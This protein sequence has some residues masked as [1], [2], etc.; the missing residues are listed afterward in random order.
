[1]SGVYSQVQRRF[2][3][4]FI[5][6]IITGSRSERRGWTVD[7]PNECWALLLGLY[8]VHFTRLCLQPESRGVN[9][10]C[11][12]GWRDVVINVSSVFFVVS[13][14]FFGWFYKSASPEGVLWGGGQRSDAEMWSVQFVRGR[15][16]ARAEV[17]RSIFSGPPRAAPQLSGTSS[18]DWIALTQ[19]SAPQSIPS[20]I[21]QLHSSTLL[22]S[23]LSGLHLTCDSKRLNIKHINVTTTEMCR[24]A[25]HIKARIVKSDHTEQLT[26]TAASMS[27]SAS[28]TDRKYLEYYSGS[29]ANE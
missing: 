21:H 14:G 2:F 24:P 3:L 8:G 10:L 17:R 29:L 16:E 7:P 19:L 23:F 9:S 20:F 27:H 18:N 15:G 22:K 28:Q 13:G 5:V 4:K 12:G 25:L 6:I 1:M 26:G 11:W